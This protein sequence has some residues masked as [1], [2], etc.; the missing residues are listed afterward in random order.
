MRFLEDHAQLKVWKKIPVNVEDQ[1]YLWYRER[2]L[3]VSEM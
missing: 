3:V 2:E 1:I